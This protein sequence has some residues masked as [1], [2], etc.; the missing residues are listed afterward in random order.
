[1]IFIDTKDTKNPNTP[2]LFALAA[3]NHD[4]N[5]PPNATKSNNTP[6]LFTRIEPFY[7]WIAALGG[8]NVK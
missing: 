1:V 8:P 7:K 6:D 4:K 2:K 5:C 3:W